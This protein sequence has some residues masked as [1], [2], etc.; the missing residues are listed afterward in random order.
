M[1]KRQPLQS[2]GGSAVAP[3]RLKTLH[4]S[5]A[6]H[7]ILLTKCRHD[8]GRFGKYRL[9]DNRRASNLDRVKRESVFVRRIGRDRVFEAILIH[10][11]L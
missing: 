3:R 5:G 2:I 4:Q 10:A 9:H 1:N 7:P 11:A 8:R 6:G